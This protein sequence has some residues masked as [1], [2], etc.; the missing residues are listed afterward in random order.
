MAS[1][2]TK[3]KV[4]AIAPQN[5]PAKT[6]AVLLDVMSALAAE[7]QLDVLLQKIMEKTSE[8]LDAD[9]STLF[10]VDDAK[11]ELWSKVAQG[12]DMSEIRFPVG[13]GIAGHVARIG[14]TV[15][16]PDAYKDPR[17]NQEIDR[18]TGYRTRTILCMPMRT[19]Q[20]KI[21]GVF[22]VLNKRRGVFSQAD[23]GLLEAFASQ[24]GIAVRNAM[25]NEEIE[26]RMA[27]SEI[28]LSVMRE[29]SS[30][31]EIDPLLKK[32]VSQTSEA[33]NAERC[34]LFLVDRVTGELWSKVA[35]GEA[36]KEI[37]VPKGA[38]IAGHVAT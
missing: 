10:L 13:A 27:T 29:V 3:R 21:L 12:K 11:Q 22:Q 20:G 32:I 7:R 34:T 37:R 18:R 8:V 16:I 28:L 24:A 14:E 9:R 26:K 17:F 31:L 4:R 30:E 2:S 25:L 1:K 6:Y 35:Q 19:R 38:G 5:T 36:M 33:M 23:E 15:N